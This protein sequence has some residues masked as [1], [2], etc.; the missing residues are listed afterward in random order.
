M[1][2]TEIVTVF[3]RRHALEGP[4]PQ[5]GQTTLD[6]EGIPVTLVKTPAHLV[7]GAEIGE[8]PAGGRAEFADLLLEA[9]LESTS[10]FAK[11]RETGRYVLLRILPLAT[12]NP[13]TFDE[14]LE[15]LVNTAETWRRLLTDFRP[16]STEASAEAAAGAEAPAFGPGG[17]LQV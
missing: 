6:I 12:L 17:F 14:A 15:T 11:V 2:F 1:D 8:P 4:V 16:A 13:D 5:T 9:N 7:A 3:A 10:Y